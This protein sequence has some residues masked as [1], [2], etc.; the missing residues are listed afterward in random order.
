M[1]TKREKDTDRVRHVRN[2]VTQGARARHGH[3]DREIMKDRREKQ[4]ETQQK[5][6][7][8]D[9]PVTVIT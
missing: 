6:A 9:S 7:G 1:E 5:N 8:V 3:P 2:T 4:R